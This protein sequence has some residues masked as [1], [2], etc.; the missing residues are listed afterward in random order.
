MRSERLLVNLFVCEDPLCGGETSELIEVDG[1]QG[2]SYIERQPMGEESVRLVSSI[3]LTDEQVIK[4]LNE[5][6]WFNSDIPLELAD[7]SVVEDISSL[8]EGKYPLFTISGAIP[9][10]SLRFR[11]WAEGWIKEKGI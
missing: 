4:L 1:P 3:K 7:I 8:M 6:N 10:A 11:E 9:E 5:M 2:F